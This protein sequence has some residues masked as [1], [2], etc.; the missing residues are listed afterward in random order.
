MARPRPLSWESLCSTH[1]TGLPHDEIV[2]IL[3]ARTRDPLE[4]RG[5]I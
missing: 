5:N 3:P 1:S 4:E 2:G